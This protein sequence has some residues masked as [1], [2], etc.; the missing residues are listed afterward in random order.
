MGTGNDGG[1][2]VLKRRKLLQ[3]LG[4]VGA[5]G[6]AGCGQL[7]GNGDGNGDLGERV[8]TVDLRYWA[9]F[10]AVTEL[11]E[12]IAPVIQEDLAKIGIDANVNGTQA[13][14][15]VNQSFNDDRQVI[16]NMG[17]YTH[18]PDPARL[19]PQEF[20][21]RFAIDWAGPN[22]KGN[23]I[24]YA[25]CEYSGPAI[26]QESAE[27]QEQRQELVREASVLSSG[28]K[29]Q[30]LLAPNVVYGAW[31]NQRV[32]NVEGAIGGRGL[33]LTNPNPFIVAEATGDTLRSSV[34]SQSV[35]TLN[36]ITH[37]DP[38]AIV[39]MNNLPNSPLLTYDRNLELQNMLAADF[40]DDHPTE[41]T[42]ELKDA[43]FHD[44]QTVTA[45]DVKF[46]Y[47]FLQENNGLLSFG[48]NMFIDS[49]EV[50]D[51]KTA[52]FHL[53]E[54]FPALV[55]RDWPSWGIMHREAMIDSGL[56]DDP[57]AWEPSADEFIGSGPFAI[58]NFSQ[59]T[60]LEFEP[61]DG[62]PE[63]SPGHNLLFVAYDDNV[64]AVQALQSGELDMGIQMALG[65]IQSLE[66]EMPDQITTSTAPV[67]TPHMLYQQYHIGPTKFDAFR[68]AVGTVINRNA[69]N[70]LGFDGR[71]EMDTYAGVLTESHPFRPPNEEL[72]QFT[73]DLG[74]DVEGARAKLEEAGFGW[75]DDDNLRYPPDADLEPLWPAGEFPS[76][77]DFPCV[78][79]EGNWTGEA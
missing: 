44:G 53:T 63:Y 77:S 51:E 1:K 75:D 40:T 7:T 57:E 30:V 78:D 3:S 56:T 26:A 60:S 52:T 71:N 49:V 22:G 15:M 28:D 64:A 65:N 38:R 13:I 73:D 46:T 50:V 10:G 33:S 48:G 27:S 47:E 9:A 45:E 76:E 20:V 61:H 54:P 39:M 16:W 21:R 37:P 36:W 24:N 68:D 19:D 4:V 62:H 14:E 11:H 8:Q 70:D 5:G 18:S 41:K 35:E 32:G 79:G 59:S 43:T 74:G 31:R 17:C 42:V 66:E 55:T 29:C 12:N 34:D 58:S 25:S 23:M 6:L 2:G 69:I 72:H 67:Y